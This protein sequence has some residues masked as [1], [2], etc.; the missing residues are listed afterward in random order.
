[1]GVL[2]WA[3]GLDHPYRSRVRRLGTISILQCHPKRKLVRLGVPARC[4]LTSPGYFGRERPKGSMT[5]TIQPAHR[6]GCSR[7][8]SGY[9]L[10]GLSRRLTGRSNYTLSGSVE[11]LPRDSEHG[12]FRCSRK[13]RPGPGFS[14][15]SRVEPS[16]CILP[17]PTYRLQHL[18]GIVEGIRAGVL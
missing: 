2:E 17:V 10:P 1:M 8:G 9:P 18:V 14:A 11:E 4:R 6:R 12:L 5:R 16:Y 13:Q 3:Y 15:G 7:A